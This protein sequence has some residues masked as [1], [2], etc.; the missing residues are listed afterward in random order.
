MTFGIVVFPGSNCDEDAVY[1]LESV[2]KQRV[3]KIWHK[4]TSLKNIDFVIIPGGFSY[5]DYLRSGAIARFSPIMKQIIEFANNGGYVLGICNGFQIL[6]EAGLLPGTLMRNQNHSFVCKNVFIKPQHNLTIFT[7]EIGERGVFKIPIAHAEGCY[8]ADEVTLQE[9]VSNKQIIFKYCDENG[10]INKQANPNGS[11]K[12]IA[13]IC[14][15]KRNVF[16]MMPHPE[17]ACDEELNNID[18][19]IILENA[20]NLFAKNMGK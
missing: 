18:G 4:E 20:I 3:V 6:C 19:K 15:V 5:G 8:F 9:I 13:G 2:L 1:A 7:G 16:G 11:L 12:N 17:R 14:N 10:E